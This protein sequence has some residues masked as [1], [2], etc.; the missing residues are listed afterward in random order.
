[1]ITKVDFRIDMSTSLELCDH[2]EPIVIYDGDLIEYDDDHCPVDVI[3]HFRFTHITWYDSGLMDDFSGQLFHLDAAIRSLEVF[4]A[5]VPP[6]AWYLDRLVVLP[7]YQRRGVGSN[8]LY[9]LLRHASNVSSIG[10]FV[11]CTTPVDDDGLPVS[12]KRGH[13]S[14]TIKHLA[15]STAHVARRR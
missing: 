14:E 12:K 8:C 5:E 2:L 1:V 6:T 15:S 9:R 13:E 7:Q 4:A 11:V 10:V 3:G